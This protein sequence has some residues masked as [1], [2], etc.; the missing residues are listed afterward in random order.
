MLD[1]YQL[2]EWNISIEDVGNFS[3]K[4]EDKIIKCPILKIEKTPLK[5]LFKMIDHEI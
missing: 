1:I 3:V 4:H 5:D 2:D